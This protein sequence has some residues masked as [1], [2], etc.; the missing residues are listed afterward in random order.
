MSIT[1]FY[2]FN[3]CSVVFPDAPFDHRYT[4]LW[5]MKLNCRPC[6]YFLFNETSL[7]MVLQPADTVVFSMSHQELKVKNFLSFNW[8]DF[9]CWE[10]RVVKKR[11]RQTEEHR[12]WKERLFCSGPEWQLRE[13]RTHTLRSSVLAAPMQLI[14]ILFRLRVKGEG[15]GLYCS[16][17]TSA[18]ASKADLVPCSKSS[19]P[20]FSKWV[21]S[22]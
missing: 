9:S 4:F 7:Q 19:E 3:M 11:V 8:C 22:L 21:I 10:T 2:I 18:A 12:K 13:I 1:T 16:V 6:I 15:V 14:I 20:S 5:F 17:C